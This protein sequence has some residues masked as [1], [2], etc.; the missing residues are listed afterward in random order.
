MHRL[1]GCLW[2]AIPLVVS[3]AIQAAPTG[4][5]TISAFQLRA[6]EELNSCLVLKPDAGEDRNEIIEVING[7]CSY[8]GALFW[9]LGK[10]HQLIGVTKDVEKN[11][12][13]WCL[14]REH[15]YYGGETLSVRECYDSVNEAQSWG[16]DSKGLLYRYKEGTGRVDTVPAVGILSGLD[17]GFWKGSFQWVHEEPRDTNWCYTIPWVEKC[18][19]VCASTVEQP[20]CE[21]GGSP[22]PDP[23]ST[24][25][26]TDP[27]PPPTPTQ[28]GDSGPISSPYPSPSPTTPETKPE[29]EDGEKPPPTP[30][31]PTPQP[32]PQP[33]PEPEVPVISKM[34]AWFALKQA[35]TDDNFCLEAQ[36]F[37]VPDKSG[38]GYVMVKRVSLQYCTPGKSSQLWAHD[39]V[40]K[41]VFNKGFEEKNDDVCLT[42]GNT[43]IR[44]TPCFGRGQENRSQMWY[45]S[46]SWTSGIP[47]AA[48][49]SYTDGRDNWKYL[50]DNP[51]KARLNHRVLPKYNGDCERVE[52]KCYDLTDGQLQDYVP[53]Y[54]N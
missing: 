8:E 26:P 1:T 20:D 53:F 45:F 38:H 54:I 14:T 46:R 19:H 2:L 43:G 33:Q 25:T 27:T 10:H 12:S 41:Q 48:L 17:M 50:L 18:N 35:R 11:E 36:T 4:S 49:L 5:D 13:L 34:A 6:S 39:L 32:Q 24:P 47:H 21:R 7:S 44:M 23:T 30:T 9:T 37:Q 51:Q 22:K 31:Q 29:P 16:F 3:A 42:K 40:T 28:P 15:S 52:G